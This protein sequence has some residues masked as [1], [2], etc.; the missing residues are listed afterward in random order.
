ME[1]KD[2]AIQDLNTAIKLNPQYFDAQANLGFTYV[3][4]ENYKKAIPYFNKA[5]EINPNFADVY[6]WRGSCYEELKELA[7][8]RADYTTAEKL[9]YKRQEGRLF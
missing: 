1:Q 4:M 3:S 2:K 5:I 8:A 6:V 9:G 7:K